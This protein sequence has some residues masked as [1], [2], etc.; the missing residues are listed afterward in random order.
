[1]TQPHHTQLPLFAARETHDAWTV[2]ISAR[3]RRLSVRVYPAGRVE[4]VVPPRTPAQQVQQFV[5]RHRTWID[6]RVQECMTQRALLTAPTELLLPSIERSVQVEY[7]HESSL[8]RLRVLDSHHL[9]IRGAVVEPARWSRL[10]SNWL[11]ALAQQEL[12]KRLQ[13][14][15]HTYDFSFERLQVRRQRTRWGSCSSS[16]TIS[17]NVCSLFL[18]PEVLRYLLI[19]EL[20]HTRHMNHSR[21]FWSLVADCEPGFA[22]LD[23]ELTRAWRHVPVWMF[24]GH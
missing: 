15:A 1:M 2:R 23:K 4:I 11:V 19:H 10:L 24:M 7:R 20:C 13:H 5:S 16:G 6:A 17:L 18:R 14:L 21:R 12:F 9:L 8:P 22:E 3:A